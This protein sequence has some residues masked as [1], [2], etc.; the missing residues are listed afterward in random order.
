MLPVVS[1]VGRSGSGK[2]MLMEQLIAEFKGRGY[3]V[4]ALKHTRRPVEIDTPGKDSWRFSQAGS[5]AVFVSS[6][7][8]LAFTKSTDHDL[9]MQEV[10]DILG[11]RFDLILAEGFKEGATPKIEVH[12][13]EFGAELL[14]SPGD[15][16]AVI[17]DGSLEIGVTQLQRG[18]VPAIADFI[19]GTFLSRPPGKTAPQSIRRQKDYR[20][21]EAHRRHTDGQ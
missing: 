2:T 16:A 19:E 7:G 15:L 17:T 8:R 12:R 3:R 14:C 9:D 20:E 11:P 18:D 4:A 13:R 5:D 6:P 21:D 1:I 10:M